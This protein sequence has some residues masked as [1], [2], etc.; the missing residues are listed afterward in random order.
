MKVYIIFISQNTSCDSGTKKHMLFP[1]D[2]DK[3]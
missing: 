1:F 3:K 2:L